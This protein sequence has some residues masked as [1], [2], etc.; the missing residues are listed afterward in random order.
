MYA[1]NICYLY[2]DLLNLYGDRGNVIAIKKRCEWKRIEA[3]VTHVNIGDSFDAE[4]YDIVIIGG[5]QDYEQELLRPDL[6]NEKAGEIKSYIKNNGVLLAICGGYQLLGHYYETRKGK[7][8]EFLGALDF[9]T[10]AGA[11]RMIG[12]MVFECDFLKTKTYDGMVVGFEN[13]MGKTFLGPGVKPMGRVVRGNGNNGEDEFEGAIYKNTLCSYAHGSLLPKNPALA[14]HLI[15]MAL[16][17]KYGKFIPSLQ[18]ND[19][20]EMQAHHVNLMRR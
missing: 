5:G 15:S 17:Q 18:L 14:D 11:K 1:I 13:H 9:M 2:P 10:I 8:L 16:K 3:N 6:L 19:K 12:N 4:K 7:K 20:L